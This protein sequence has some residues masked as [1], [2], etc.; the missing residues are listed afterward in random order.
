MSKLERT[1]EASGDGVCWVACPRRAGAGPAYLWWLGI[2]HDCCHCFLDDTFLLCLM[3]PIIFFFPRMCQLCHYHCG[4]PKAH[5]S[6]FLLNSLWNLSVL[7]QGLSVLS[8]PFNFF[9]STV[10]AFCCIF[11]YES[12]CTWHPCQSAFLYF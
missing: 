3:K 8:P 11:W 12:V 10:I 6:C 4:S 1:R 5:Q 9:S 7:F 2:C